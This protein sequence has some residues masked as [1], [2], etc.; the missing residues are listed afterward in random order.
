LIQKNLIVCGALKMKCN[1]C[2]EEILNNWAITL[3][4]VFNSN[5]T[6]D[7]IAYHSICNPKNTAKPNWLKQLY[8]LIRYGGDLK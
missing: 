7:F 4:R 8:F 3:K 2:N 6:E 5:G 1:K